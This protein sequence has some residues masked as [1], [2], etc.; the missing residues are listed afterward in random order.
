MKQ[1]SINKKISRIT[2]DTLIVGIDVAKRTHWIRMMDFR[3]I[4]L[5]KPFKINN[6]MDGIK[7]LEEKIK[8]VKEENKLNKVVLGMEPSGHYWKVLAWQMKI[9][10]EID[11]L[12][13]VNPYHVKKSKEFDDNSPGKSDR[14]DAGVIARLIRD[15][16]YF[17]IYLPEDIY[18]ELRVITTTREQLVNKRKNAKNMVISVMDEYFPEYEKIY[19]NIFSEGSIKLLKTHPFPKEI[20]EVGIEEIEKVLKKS[21]NG[22]DWKS[23][24]QKIYESAKK[25]IGV[26]EGQKSAK[27]KLRML[28]EEIEFLTS[29]IEELEKEME[30][31]VEETEEGEYIK[32]V[33]GIGAIMTA[34][35]LGEIGDIN[36]FKSWKEIRKLAG[37]N[38]YEV[39]SG[40]HKGKTRITKRGRPL[41]RKIIYL[42]AQTTLKHN[43]EIRK[44]YEQLRRREKNPLKAV[45]ALIAIG[46]KMIR[47]VFKLAKSKIKYEPEKVYV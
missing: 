36:R 35:I 21:T 39:S 37:L 25:S 38:L 41:L 27:I 28:L 40:E 32:S 26:R 22:K 14:K 4:D 6:T 45:Q 30:K 43:H 8:S 31:L 19:K 12:V 23:R 42:M 10:K 34:I 33:P 44:K 15:G 11:Y 20:I 17:D 24:A 1:K 5:I 9:S 16:R 47:I 2:Q 46:L 7:M 29:Q 13:G 3:G 18:G